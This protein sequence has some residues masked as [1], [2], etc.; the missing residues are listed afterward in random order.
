MKGNERSR[1]ELAVR[2]LE[3]VVSGRIDEAYERFIDT[4][5]KHH[6]PYF[7]AGFPA[8][9]R[10]MIENHARFPDKRIAVKRIIAEGD[11]VAA[12]SQVT[13]NPGDKN[14]AVV[15]L[16]RFQEGR[17]VELWDI[18]QP[19]EPDSPNRDGMF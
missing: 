2:F 9:K 8:L 14:I 7:P 12:H 10:A 19:I 16:F 3:L 13:L 18:G 1:K 17:I 4:A 6:N 11:M 5:G 15:H